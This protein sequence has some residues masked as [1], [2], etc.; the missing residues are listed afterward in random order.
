MIATAG[1]IAAF[2]I[3]VLAVVFSDA[4]HVRDIAKLNGCYEADGIP[5]PFRTPN[6][7]A[8]KLS[9]GALIDRSGKTISHVTL[10]EDM[11]KSTRTFFTPGV[12][13]I[14]DDRR[15]L[16]AKQGNI[17]SGHAQTEYWGISMGLDADLISPVQS[18]SC[19]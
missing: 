6:R 1:R 9:N 11:P 8:F 17:V 15:Y 12:S 5:S 18:T 19:G 2:G 16:F 7:W 14:D 13:F 4:G 3:V 10:G